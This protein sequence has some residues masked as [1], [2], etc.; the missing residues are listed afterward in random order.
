M[1]LKYSVFNIREKYA[2]IYGVLWHDAVIAKEELPA[3]SS[4][5][6]DNTL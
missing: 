3:S 5:F 4:L 1:L 2:D 6:S